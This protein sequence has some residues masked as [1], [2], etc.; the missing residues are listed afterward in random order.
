MATAE[1]VIVV[2]F[3]IANACRLLAYVPQI[4]VLLRERDTSAVSRATW[5]LFLVSNGMTAIYAAWVA[6]DM[7]MALVFLANT[8]CCA[9]IVALV[10]QK[11][12]KVCR[13]NPHPEAGAGS[14]WLLRS[15]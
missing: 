14:R 4:V 6:A 7:T 11:R 1:T 9:A 8:F 15:R 2:A 3:S 12:R 13:S 5:L 10:H